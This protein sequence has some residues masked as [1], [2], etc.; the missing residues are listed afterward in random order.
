MLLV[1]DTPINAE[2]VVEILRT[3]GYSIDVA[4]DGIAALEAAT[5]SEYDVVLMD[6]QL[7]GIDGYETTRRIRSLETAGKLGAHGHPVQLGSRSWP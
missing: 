7:P 1:E 3:A 5:R 6:C 4:V 2:V